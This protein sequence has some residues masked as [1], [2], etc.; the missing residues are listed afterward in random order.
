[1]RLSD[2]TPTRYQPPSRPARQFGC[3]FW[4]MLGAVG[5]VLAF[6]MV[7][8]SAFA[9]WNVGISLARQNATRTAAAELQQQCDRIQQDIAAGNTRLLA[10]R[11]GFLEAHTPAPACLV[12]LAP[13]ATAL[14]LTSLPSPTPLPT[15]T[16]P[17][18]AAATAVAVPTIAA[19]PLPGY[20]LDILLAEAEADMRRGDYQAAIDTL[21][22]ITAIDL[23]FQ[24]AHIS[25]LY[26]EALTAQA[27]ALFRSGKLSE[28]ILL[29]RRAEVYGNVQQLELNYE[30]NIA[31]LYL[32]AQRLKITNPAEAVRL[33]SL[34]VYQHSLRDYQ[35]GLVIAELQEAHRNYGDAL[36]QQGEHCQAQGQY[37][38]SLDLSAFPSRIDRARLINQHS[39]AARACSG[40]PTANPLTTA[41]ADADEQPPAPPRPTIVPVGQTG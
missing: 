35:N 40:A 1:M 20:D 23:N 19:S 12:G 2:D 10:R 39:Q 38:A 25:D 6:A 32:S 41:S 14:Y 31:E 36:S 34:I 4:L 13:R 5:L 27:T 24:R 17:P 3:L 18:P 21:D 33:F 26:F 22:A 37:Q 11:L 9:G 8:G 7:A 15:M 30:R 29:V 28:G 16:A